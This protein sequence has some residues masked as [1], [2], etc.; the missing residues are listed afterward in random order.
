MA[1]CVQL[2][3]P[4]FSTL[5]SRKSP[6]P[7]DARFIW[8]FNALTLCVFY[9]LSTGAALNLKLNDDHSLVFKEN[10][11]ELCSNYRKAV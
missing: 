2:Q 9:T 5:R 11:N 8:S 4:V 3:A 1:N 6:G 10:S 7:V